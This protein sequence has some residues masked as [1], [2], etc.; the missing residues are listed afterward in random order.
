MPH[1]RPPILGAAC[2]VALALPL[3]LAPLPA[4]AAPAPAPAPVV[5][6]KPPAQWPLTFLHADQIW[7]RTKG[8][9]ATVG[10]VD[11]G[12]SPLGDTKANLLP[13]ADFSSG[14]TSIGPAHLDTDTDSHGTTMAVLIAGAGGGLGLLGLAPE[15]KILPVRMQK[16]TGED[17]DKITNAVRWATA[18]HVKVINMSLGTTPTPALAAAVKAAQDADI[19]VVAAAGNA[20][21]GHVITPARSEERRVGKECRSRGGRCE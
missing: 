10:L 14:P 18:Q 7:Q 15:A 17:P 5:A 19:V 16:E 9:G 12:V 3:V 13:G 21:A 4:L 8:G 11:S 20:G 2:G 1:R 6:A